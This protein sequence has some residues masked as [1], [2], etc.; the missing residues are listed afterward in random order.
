MFNFLFPKSSISQKDIET[1]QQICAHENR[2]MVPD[3]IQGKIKF[4]MEEAKQHIFNI[5]LR[6]NSRCNEWPC[7]INALTGIYE[8][9]E[10]F[11]G[12]KI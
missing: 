1:M 2:Q 4:T 11:C 3:V 10:K 8:K 12:L 9:F 7:C 5:T 6:C